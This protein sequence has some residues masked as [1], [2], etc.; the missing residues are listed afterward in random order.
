MDY[1]ISGLPLQ[2]FAPLFGLD[3]RA[4][5]RRGIH[6]QVAGA[7]GGYPCRI[8]LADAAPG[9]SL[10]LLPWT[11]LDV[12]TPYRA[13]GPIFVREAAAARAVVRNQVP[14]QQRIRLLSVRAYDAEGWML[15]AAVTE[16]TRL[17]EVIERLFADPRVAFLHAHNAMRGCYA[18]RIDRG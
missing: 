8:T 2:A 11:H 1:I 3:A 18:C 14:E 17:E 15:D 4:L 12:D 13:A 5:E 10:L 16:G 7:G 9:E 6:R